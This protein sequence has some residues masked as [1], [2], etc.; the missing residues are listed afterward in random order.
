MPII[1]TL[2]ASV[3]VLS[4]PAPALADGCKLFGRVCGEAQNN[5]PWTIR[6]T[7]KLN[8]GRDWCDVWNG[9]GGTAES[10]WHTQC[11]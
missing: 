10:W 6:T 4:S 1:G 11:E 3:A 5:S 9:N 7:E 8:S 2:V